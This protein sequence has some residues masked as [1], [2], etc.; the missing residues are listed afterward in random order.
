MHRQLSASRTDL[1]CAKEKS[2]ASTAARPSRP[3]M[4]TP[5]CAER[6]MP[7]SLAPSPMPKVIAPALIFT[8]PVTW[9]Q[10]TA[11]SRQQQSVENDVSVGAGQLQ[12]STKPLLQARPLHAC[13]TA[14]CHV[15][16]AIKHLLCQGEAS[17]TNTTYLCFLLRCY[18]AA[19]NRPALLAQLHQGIL[20]LLVQRVVKRTTLYHNAAVCVALHYLQ[21][22]VL[23]PDL[24]Q[25]LGEHLQQEVAHMQAWLQPNINS[26]AADKARAEPN[27]FSTNQQCTHAGN[28]GQ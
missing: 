19:H 2:D 17:S 15:L 7:T 11:Q 9:Q 27:H 23:L 25:L 1:N 13:P 16:A 6:I 5:M 12:C 22:L 20:A 8:M 26:L 4:P 24:C 18:S 14:H 28:S 21:Q 10:H 3:L